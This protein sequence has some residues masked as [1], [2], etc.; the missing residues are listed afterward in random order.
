[1][2][3]KAFSILLAMGF[4]C[5]L[6]GT[7]TAADLFVKSCKAYA[8][9]NPYNPNNVDI[10]FA[11]EVCTNDTFGWFSENVEVA[12]FPHLTSAPSL[13]VTT[14]FYSD[15]IDLGGGWGGWY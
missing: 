12:F 6:P 11:A 2:K 14:G 3:N 15:F 7:A 1:M 5:C 13:P 10:R 9:R 4:L 8:M